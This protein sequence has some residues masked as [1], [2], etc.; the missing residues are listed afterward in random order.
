RWL[1]RSTCRPKSLSSQVAEVVIPTGIPCDR[2]C[3]LRRA[4]LVLVG[5]RGYHDMESQTIV[6]VYDAAR[7]A[8]ALRACIIEQQD[9]HRHLESSWPEGRLIVDEYAK[10]LQTQC[11]VH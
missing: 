8:E 2:G 5:L 9:F 10:Y 7:D 6:R 1:A 11:A 3:E 4:A